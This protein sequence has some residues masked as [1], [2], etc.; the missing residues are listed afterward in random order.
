M[1]EQVQRRYMSNDNANKVQEMIKEHNKLYS[2]AYKTCK[3]DKMRVVDV[4]L[5][6]PEYLWVT[7]G[8]C[9]EEGPSMTEEQW[10]QATDTQTQ[11]IEEQYNINIQINIETNKIKKD[12]ENDKACIQ[13]SNTQNTYSIQEVIDYVTKQMTKHIQDKK[14]D[15]VTVFVS[16][17]AVYYCNMPEVIDIVKRNITKDTL[18]VEYVIDHNIMYDTTEKKI[19]VAYSS[20]FDQ[21]AKRYAQG[22]RRYIIMKDGDDY[23]LSNDSSEWTYTYKRIKTDTDTEGKEQYK[24]KLMQ[25][26]L[27]RR[28]NNYIGDIYCTEETKEGKSKEVQYGLMT[29]DLAEMYSMVSIDEEEIERLDIC[30]YYSD[31]YKRQQTNNYKVILNMSIRDGKKLHAKDMELRVPYIRNIEIQTHN[32]L[33]ILQSTDNEQKGMLIIDKM[34]VRSYLPSVLD[35]KHLGIP[36]A[37]QI[38]VKEVELQYLNPLRCFDNTGL[39]PD[40]IIIH[41]GA[42]GESDEGKEQNNGLLPVIQNLHCKTGITLKYIDVRKYVSCMANKSNKAQSEVVEELADLCGITEDD[43]HRMI[44]N[45]ER[46]DLTI[47]EERIQARIHKQNEKAKMENK[48]QENMQDYVMQ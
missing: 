44:E 16:T 13:D 18:Q 17:T 24:Y 23:D 5:Y 12:I 20:A 15:I 1:E 14:I 36:N 33:D 40:R 47:T 35:T 42:L 26:G 34:I 30:M 38:Q 37:K 19:Y 48:K 25:I 10:K 46:V 9:D 2:M 11:K 29:W 28:L 22:D 32:G 21:I 41:D 39:E 4:H 3:T 27:F 8:L 7:F 6:D 43:V 31:E 45:K